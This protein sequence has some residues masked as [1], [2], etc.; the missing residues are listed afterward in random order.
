MKTRIGLAGVL[1]TTSGYLPPPRIFVKEPMVE[2]IFR[3]WSGF[4][5]ATVNAQMPPD[6]EPAM[7]RPFGSSVIF[8]ILRT[9]GRISS[10]RKREYVSDMVSYSADRFFGP[11]GR[12]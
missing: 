7:A 10:R 5:H 12:P 11:A 3:N 9:S 1:R 8:T 2:K 6:D 4:S